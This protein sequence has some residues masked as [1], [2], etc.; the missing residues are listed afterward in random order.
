MQHLHPTQLGILSK[1]L[2]AE[3]LRYTDLKFDPSIENN[4]FQ[5]HLDKVITAGYVVKHDGGYS[6]TQEGKKYA[7]H[8]DT[9][10]QKVVE[11]RKVSVHLYCIR[12]KGAAQEVLIYTRLKQPFYRKQGFPAGKVRHGELFVDAAR[13]ELKEETNLEG[14][15]TL[16]NVLHYLVKD[17]TTGALLDDKLF[18]DFFITN[19]R[20]ELK[21][22]DEGEFK[23]IP[24]DDLR[25]HIENPFDSVD[26]YEQALERIRSLSGNISFEEREHVTSEF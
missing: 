19:P 26:V 5:F 24:A 2:F 15:P 9:D 3:S 14:A 4:T 7:T 10:V 17:K 21:G 22:N 16:F 25:T 20:G 18:L 23:W 1:L 11:P 12:G 13:R 8:I 6:L